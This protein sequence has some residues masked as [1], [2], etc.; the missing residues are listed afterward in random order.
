MILEGD[1]EVEDPLLLFVGLIGLNLIGL[2]FL[3]VS[4]K[5]IDKVTL[6]FF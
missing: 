5:F 1:K 3:A 2:F 4:I 6:P